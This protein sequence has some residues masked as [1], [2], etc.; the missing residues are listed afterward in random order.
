MLVPRR[1]S[2]AICGL[3]LVFVLPSLIHMISLK[4]RGE[5]RWPSAVFH[6]F[7]HPARG[8]QSDRPVLHVARCAFNEPHAVCVYLLEE[9]LGVLGT[10]PWVLLTGMKSWGWKYKQV[11]MDFITKTHS[12]AQNV[13]FLYILKGFN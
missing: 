5:L 10:V 6:S 3:A 12:K 4:R 11:P 13:L 9:E 1:Y 7:P 8:G 2:G